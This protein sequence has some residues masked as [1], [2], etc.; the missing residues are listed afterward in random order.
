MI[1]VQL[2]PALS[3]S[4]T[5]AC[6]AASATVSPYYW[7][8]GVYNDTSPTNHTGSGFTLNPQYSMLTSIVG[9]GYASTGTVR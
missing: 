6:P 5:G 4:T 2:V 8:I 7:D 1:P 9:T 3:Q